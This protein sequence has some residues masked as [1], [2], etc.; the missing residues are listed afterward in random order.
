M[1]FRSGVFFCDRQ[2]PDQLRFALQKPSLEK[3]QEL[4]A[5]Y[6]FLVDT[7]IWLLS[8]RAV[9]VLLKKCGGENLQPYEMYASMGLA[10]GSQPT[11]PD[12][13]VSALTTAIVPMPQGEFYHFGTTRDLIRSV[14]ALQSAVVDQRQLG[15]TNV[16]PL[17]DQHTQNAVIQTGLRAD[18]H[19]LWIE[20][21]HVAAGWQLPGEHMITGAPANDWKLAL[22]RG[23]CLDIVPVG[24]S[25]FAIRPY[26]MDDSFRGP[27]GDPTTQWLGKPVGEWFAARGIT[28]AE[29]GIEPQMDLQDAPLFPVGEL[30]TIVQ[31]LQPGKEV[32]RWWCKARRL[33]AQ[34]L[35]EQVNLRRMF[36]QRAAHRDA[37]LAPLARNHQRSVFY[38]LDLADTG[39]LYAATKH[40]L[41]PELPAD[42]EPLKRVHDEMFRAAVLRRRGVAAWEQHESRAFGVLRELLLRQMEAEPVA[43]TRRVL[44]DQ[45]VWGRAPVRLDL[46]GGWTDTPPYCLQHG[47]RVV[48]V[49]VNLNGQ[50]PLQV[51]ARVGEKPELVIR[52]IDLGIEERVRTFEELSW[53]DQVGSGFTIAKA[54]LA[55]AGFLPRFGARQ[56]SLEQQ[57]REFGGGLEI[58]LLSAVPKGS[59]LGTSSILAATL[60]GTLSEVCGLNWTTQQIFQRTSALEQMLTTGGGWQDQ[61]GGVLRGLKLV[62]TEEGLAQTPVVRWLTER[63]WGPEFADQTVLLYYTGITRVA[64][65]ILQEIVRGMFLNSQPHLAILEDIGANADA[66]ADA[67]Q[68]DDWDGM[69][70]AVRRSWE[71]NQRLDSGTN[72]PGVQ[73]IMAQVSDWLAGAKLLGA[74]GGGYL[75]M[76]A[77]DIEA[78]RRVR[79]SLTRQPPNAKARFVGLSLSTTGLQVTRS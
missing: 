34:E 27:V 55:L 5:Q 23:V 12:P 9:N 53:Y 63:F 3:I 25:E 49:G 35:S 70:A 61:V 31:M 32:G 44:D 4:S 46:A 56:S 72:P 19:L 71:L 29:A 16:D 10:L 50:P 68:R 14:T 43:P 69:T 58:S 1:L 66:I 78:A 57:L 64:K 36:A 41:P 37:V 79:E 73:A 20:N 39:R 18:Q 22:P 77:K 51:F 33:S 2:Q 52:S 7:G 59:G 76:Y 62:Q 38:K 28:L 54:A 47:G 48:N 6:L 40:E 45:I 26:G 8:E 11:A 17:P 30:Q 67:F 13:D 24:E 15:L 65:G 42:A 74:G 60:L 75:L 21:S